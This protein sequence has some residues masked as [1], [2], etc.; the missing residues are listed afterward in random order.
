MKNLLSLLVFIVIL[1]STFMGIMMNNINK[2]LDGVL[3]DLEL[4][5][6]DP[7]RHMVLREILTEEL[8]GIGSN[9]KWASISLRYLH[10]TQISESDIDPNRVD[11]ILLSPQG[12]PWHV[13][14]RE[15]Q[16]AIN[17][18]KELLV[19]AIRD[20]RIPVLGICGGHQFLALAFGGTVGFVD[21][22][23][24]PIK[25]YSYPKHG[26]AER[27]DVV[28][29]TLADDPL[30]IGVVDHPG[31]FCVSESHFEEVKTVPGCF[32]NLARSSLSE[33][34]LLRLPHRL[35]YGFAF[36]PE[37]GWGRGQAN[38]AP[39]K[40]LLGNFF[41][42]VLDEKQ[43]KGKNPSKLLVHQTQNKGEPAWMK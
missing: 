15:C 8:T 2:G 37:R 28:L 34:Q 26:L 23:L 3:I 17:R 24:D 20:Y 27:G 10:F 40:K 1:A 41:S 18:V 43:N 4:G 6:P 42:M 39:G 16:T 12:T 7:Q 30:F 9:V 5:I 29:E 36:H 22:R 21:E 38:A 31:T 32:V 19:R 35:V 13:Y 33:I 14:E 11:F 25:P